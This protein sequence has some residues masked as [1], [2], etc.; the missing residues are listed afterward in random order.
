[1]SV[2]SPRKKALR[3]PPA[4]QTYASDDLASSKYYMLTLAERGLMESMRRVYWIEDGIPADAE[5]LASAVRR[6]AEEVRAALSQHV[7]DYFV[8][9]PH[10]AS[11]LLCRVLAGQMAEQMDRRRKQSEGGKEGARKTN[12]SARSNRSSTSSSGSMGDPSSE[13]PA[14]EVRRE[15][16]SRDEKPQNSSTNNRCSSSWRRTE[17]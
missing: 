9:N 7:L 5:V 10:D 6:P 1:M 15:G 17:L 3:R 4:Y 12:S 16:L 8:E 13:P 14:P 2:P 11:K